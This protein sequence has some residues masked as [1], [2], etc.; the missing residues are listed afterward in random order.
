MKIK[1]LCLALLYC[2]CWVQLDPAKSEER[3]NVLFIAM[4]VWCALV[5]DFGR[6]FYAVAGQ[7][8]AIDS[9]RSRKGQR[10]YKTKHQTRELLAA[11]S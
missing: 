2:V 8:R 1:H 11:S 9:C 6:L 4:E 5:R 7:P 10:R 3:Q